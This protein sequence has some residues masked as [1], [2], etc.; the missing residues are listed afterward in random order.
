[1]GPRY[2]ILTVVDD[3]ENLYRRLLASW[4]DR[5]ATGFSGLFTDDGSLV[6]FDGSPVESRASISEHLE[7]IFA[8]HEPAA[9]VAKVREVR[10]LAPG[11]GLLRSVAA[12]VPPGA[13]DIEPDVNTIQVV[14]AVEG[15]GGSAWKIAHF[16]NTPAAFHGQPEAAEALSAE[17]RAVLA[18]GDVV[19][20]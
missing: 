19:G 1:M 4:N 7:A 13:T 2:G 12:M 16:Q 14:V 9:F 3:I 10:P 20:R 17:L 18:S 6:G 8:D 15:G 5:D 11:V